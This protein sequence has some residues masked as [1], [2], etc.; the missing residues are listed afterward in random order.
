MT[1]T[2]VLASRNQGK[3]RELA[4][5]LRPFTVTVKGLDAFPEIG[6][7]AETG[8]TFAENALLKAATASKATG[9]VAVADDSGLIVDALGGE[10]GVFSARYSQEPGCPATD[11]RNTRKVLAKAVDVPDAARTCRFVS[12]MAAAAP[13]GRHII[14]EAAWEGLLARQPAGGNGF[15]YDPVFFDP[16]LGMTAAQMRPDQKNARSHRAKA[17]RKLLLLWPDFWREVRG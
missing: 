4:V 5:L 2:V 12:V 14:A 3:I 17:C 13:D 10:P 1:A 15:G 7:I 16:E 9:M 8:T 6:E 11:A